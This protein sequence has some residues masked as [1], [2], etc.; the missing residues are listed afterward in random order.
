MFIFLDTE[1]SNFATKDLISIGLVSEDETF[2]FY[3]VLNDFPLKNCSDFVKEN[4]LDKID[5]IQDGISYDQLTINLINALN[6]LSA[7]ELVFVADYSGD[8]DLLIKIFDRANLLNLSLNKRKSFSLLSNALHYCSIER[9]IFNIKVMDKASQVF[10]L[11]ASNYLSQN[12]KM[13]HHAL[14]DAKSNLFGWKAALKFLK[15]S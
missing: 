4:I 2:E 7:N 13:Q 1:F 5:F 3:H 6:K 10:V 12:P 8:F 15:N 9:G 14:F 11:E